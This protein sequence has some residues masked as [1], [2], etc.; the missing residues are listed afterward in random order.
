MLDHLDELV[1][2]QKTFL[3]LRHRHKLDA[4]SALFIH[5]LLVLLC[6]LTIG[7]FWEYISDALEAKTGP[8]ARHDLG[9][10]ILQVEI[11]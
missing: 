2:R 3:A 1:I 8:T 9:A 10:A 6:C 5:N 7:G 11:E 4:L